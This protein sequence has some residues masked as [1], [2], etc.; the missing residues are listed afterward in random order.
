MILSHSGWR[1]VF[2]VSGDEEDR[3][4]EISIAQGVVAAAA[5][6]VFAKYLRAKAGADKSG[7]PVVLVGRDSRPSGSRLADVVNAVL[8]S[9]NCMPRYAGIVAAP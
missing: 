1:G 6:A 5:A 7:T 3:T 2:S 8:V 9:H 4:G